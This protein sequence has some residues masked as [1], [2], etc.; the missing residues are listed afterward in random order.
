MAD[1]MKNGAKAL[2]KE[3]PALLLDWFAQNARELPWR[4][5]RE[6]YHVWL[7]EIMLQQ[8]R[9]QAV[10]G[11]YTR[12]LQ[13]LPDI[14]ALA[15]CEENKLLKLWE[16]LGYYSRVRNLQ[17]AARVICTEHGGVF[18]TEY[19]A[20]R[21][22]PGIGDYTAGAIA[23]ICFEQPRAAVDGNVLR[24]ITRLTGDDT[25]ID[26]IP[27]RKAVAARL[28]ELYPAGQCGAFTQALMELGALVCLP[29]GAPLCEQC[30]LAQLCRA[31]KEGRTD[32]LPVKG[33]KKPRRKET[34]TVLLLWC[35]DKL[36]LCRRPEQ[37]LLA[38]LWQLPNVLG[39]LSVEQALA[40]AAEQGAEPTH[41]QSVV[42]RS[43]IFTHVEWDMTGI[44][45]RCSRE[46]PGFVW[47]DGAERAGAYALPTAF[48]QFL[49]E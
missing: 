15:A 29:N 38:G 22:L 26:S 27:F 24:V 30:P 25:P 48:R 34:L 37:G 43:H 2:P 18:P 21:A 7:S 40:W 16:G 8:T 28:E 41:P 14:P 13:A 36:A 9:V 6:P 4:R 3:L 46:A 11:Y 39:A 49:E 45:I 12:F 35:G 5:D 33:A 44:S 1:Q 10:L 47:A 42:H 20:I 32:V 17:K 31:K 19:A 23:S